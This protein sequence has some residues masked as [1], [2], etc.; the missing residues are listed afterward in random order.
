MTSYLWFLLAA[1]FEIA[2]CYAF[3]MWLRLD[4]SAWWI[5]PGL[6]S[7]VLF[8]LILTRVEASF[9]GRAYAAYGGVYIVAS[10]AWLALIERTRPMLSD[11]LGAALCLA[12]A[13]IILF[14]PRL[15]T[16]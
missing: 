6:L 4:R 5:A 8:A 16:S 7:L 2:G 15:H 3:W 14:A 1:V 12:G 13:A 10:L 9:A 11:C